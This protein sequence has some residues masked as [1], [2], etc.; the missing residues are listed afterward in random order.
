[1]DVFGY[2]AE[3]PEEEVDDSAM[4]RGFFV[5]VEDAAGRARGVAG[6]GSLHWG[7]RDKAV[8]RDINKLL[9]RE[10]YEWN[11]RNVKL[12]WRRGGE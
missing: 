4:L 10:A 1:M 5:V 3:V 11:A 12:V 9:W 7:S 2:A 8:A 6:D